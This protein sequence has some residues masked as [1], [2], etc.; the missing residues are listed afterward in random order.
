MRT[1]IHRC[2]L[3]LQV[4]TALE[5]V[6]LYDKRG[7]LDEDT[8]HRV[9]PPLIAQ[10]D[11]E[12]AQALLPVLAQEGGWAGSPVD[13]TFGNAL[14]AALVQMAVTAGTDDLIKPLHHEVMTSY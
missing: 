10:L 9:L 11:L 7:F 5:R 2:E 14:V 3:H 12:P 4:V 8:F 13:D 1:S 6:F